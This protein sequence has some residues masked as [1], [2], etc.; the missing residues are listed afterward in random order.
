MACVT[1]CRSWPDGDQLTVM[2]DVEPEHPGGLLHEAARVASET[3]AT[4]H[5]LM[6]LDEGDE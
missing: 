1:I 3:F 5:A 6:V 4:N 2:I